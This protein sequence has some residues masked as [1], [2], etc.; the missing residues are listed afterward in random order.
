M[1]AV[2]IERDLKHFNSIL[3]S[4]WM[5]NKHIIF[6]QTNMTQIATKQRRSNILKS[7][8]TTNWLKFDNCLEKRMWDRKKNTEYLITRSKNSYSKMTFQV[9]ACLRQAKLIRKMFEF[10]F[11]QMYKNDLDF[12]PTNN[13]TL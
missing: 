12:R 5:Y 7:Y 13:T 9:N 4:V 6:G 10:V 3:Y 11:K 8:F 2:S 1:L